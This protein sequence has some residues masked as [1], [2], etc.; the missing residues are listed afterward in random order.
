MRSARNPT[1][2]GILGEA[3]L[4]ATVDAPIR[5]RPGAP[6]KRVDSAVQIRRADNLKFLSEIPDGSVQLVVTSPPYNI[7]KAYEK[8]AP[9]DS[10]IRAQAQVI[11]ECIRVLS[12]RGSLCWQVGNHVQDGEIFPLDL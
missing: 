10:Y 4:L 9:L 7:G 3:A 6:H 11:A 8:A 5:R 2:P 12:P 1:L